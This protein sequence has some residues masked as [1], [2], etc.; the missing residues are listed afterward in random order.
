MKSKDNL[1]LLKED[2]KKKSPIIG[3]N[4]ALGLLKSGKAKKVYVAKNCPKDL[5][6]GLKRYSG[7]FKSEYYELDMNSDELGTLCKKPFS[8]AVLT[9]D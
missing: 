9:Y 1:E 6:E 5:K 2:L 8:I 4:F 7:I 3:A